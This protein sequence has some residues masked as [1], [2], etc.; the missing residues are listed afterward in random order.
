ME[1]RIIKKSEN[2][3]PNFNKVL[4]FTDEMKKLGSCENKKEKEYL[5]KKI[6]SK[7][8]QAIKLLNQEFLKALKTYPIPKPFEIDELGRPISEHSL[9]QV[10]LNADATDSL[11]DEV[12]CK[13]Y[14]ERIFE[15]MQLAFP[16][17]VY[18]EL[19]KKMNER[20]QQIRP[21]L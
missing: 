17:G 11:L 4:D 21:V 9:F 7:K 13:N 1:D 20:E 16:H 10:F 8:K 19:Y 14:A 5:V 15:G 3:Y 6:N 2:F 12:K 18:R